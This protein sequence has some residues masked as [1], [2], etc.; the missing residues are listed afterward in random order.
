[1]RG[2]SL[3][4]RTEEKVSI[5]RRLEGGGSSVF[6]REKKSGGVKGTQGRGGQVREIRK[7]LGIGAI[8]R[9]NGIK[10]VKTENLPRCSQETPHKKNMGRNKLTRIDEV[11]WGAE[12]RKG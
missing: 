5:K 6:L 11:Y 9:S 4:A 2:R 8:E 10:K 7:A 1:M 3:G 12:S